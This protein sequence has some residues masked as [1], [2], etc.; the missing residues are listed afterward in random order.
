MFKNE[1][2]VCKYL[3]MNVGMKMVCNKCINH[4]LCLF[5]TGLVPEIYEQ[6]FEFLSIPF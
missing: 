6:V 1:I 5:E 2:W 3:V 4:A